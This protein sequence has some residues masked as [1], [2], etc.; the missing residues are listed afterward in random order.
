M[1]LDGD[2]NEVSERS[3]VT[4]HTHWPLYQDWTTTADGAVALLASRREGQPLAASSM[5]QHAACFSDV[6]LHYVALSGG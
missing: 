5:L 2:C 3:D 1:E 6:A 4:R